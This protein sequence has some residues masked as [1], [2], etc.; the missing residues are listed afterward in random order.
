MAFL[1]GTVDCEI[2]SIAAVRIWQST[3]ILSE[4]PK[5]SSPSFWRVWCLALLPL[6]FV[7]VCPRVGDGHLLVSPH[8]I[9]VTHAILIVK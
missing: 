4:G 6:N 9:P 8:P 5:N 7:Q 1:E 2:A 3:H